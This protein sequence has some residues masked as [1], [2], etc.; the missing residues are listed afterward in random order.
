M[1]MTHKMSNLYVSQAVVAMNVNH[2][3]VCASWYAFILSVKT[4]STPNARMVS[5]P[6]SVV[7]K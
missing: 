1:K 3:L 2:A 4:S 7:E 5:K 6:S